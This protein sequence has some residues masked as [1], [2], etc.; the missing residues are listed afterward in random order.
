MR[1]VG[2]GNQAPFPRIV[3]DRIEPAPG[4]G[5]AGR[6]VWGAA[7]AADSESVQSEFKVILREGRNREVRRLWQAVGFEVSRLT[8]L[9]YG[10]VACRPIC[11]PG[12][13]A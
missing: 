12:R 11:G 13:A 7:D 8:R 2:K 6:A 9:R 1:A 3:F 5:G 4:F 10:Q